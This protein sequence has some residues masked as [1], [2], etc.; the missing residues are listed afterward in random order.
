MKTTTQIINKFKSESKNKYLGK[1][2]NDLAVQREFLDDISKT[3][4]FT[5]ENDFYSLSANKIR[6][7]GGEN[8]SNKYSNNYHKLLTTIY[9]TKEW[10]LRQISKPKCFWTLSSN[11]REIVEVIAKDLKVEK[12]EDWYKVQTKDFIKH[13]GKIILGPFKGD[14][15]KLLKEAYPNEEWDPSFKRITSRNFWKPLSIQQRFFDDFFKLFNFQSMEDWYNVTSNEIR[16]LNGGRTILFY[17]SES[18]FAALKNCYPNYPW[19]VRLRKKVGNNYWNSI[20]NQ[21]TFFDELFQKLNLKKMDDWYKVKTEK[22]RENGGRMILKKH[23]TL[24]NALRTVYPH[25]PWKIE[26]SSSHDKFRHLTSNY[27]I[28]MIKNHFLIEKK[29]DWYRISK[30]QADRVVNGDSFHYFN[31]IINLLRKKYP[32]EKWETRELQRNK[33]SNQR[34]LFITLKKLFKNYH[35]YEEY[36]STGL[37]Y[38]SG[39]EITFDVFIPAR[40]LAF[41]YQGAQHYEDIPSCFPLIELYSSRDTQKVQICEMNQINLIAVPYWISVD[42]V[43]SLLGLIHQPR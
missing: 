15:M 19:D 32:E 4:K 43:S 40:N 30:S 26:L 6:L 41:E 7:F 42:D 23:K 33:R 22:I 8:I 38:E 13:G 16:S 3:L 27:F 5:S 14:L 37:V 39:Y 25:I 11:L 31:G 36:Y 9:P 18:L 12:K 2:W 34:L 17:Y 1:D 10:D 35:I 28:A 20:D 29:E 21:R 24:F